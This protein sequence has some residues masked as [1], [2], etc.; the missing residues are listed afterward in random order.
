MNAEELDPTSVSHDETR[1]K[2]ELSFACC[3]L[4][5]ENIIDL[6]TNIHVMIYLLFSNYYYFNLLTVSFSGT[7][8]I[9][10]NVTG[11][12]KKLYILIQ[13]IY[14]VLN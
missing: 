12:W 3:E 6:I 2:H 13:R 1:G 7:D 14:I 9:H 10:Y 4:S 8:C 11:C 5:N